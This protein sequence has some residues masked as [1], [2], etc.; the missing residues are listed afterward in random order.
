MKNALKDPNAV[1]DVQ[2]LM[3][4]GLGKL[5]VYGVPVEDLYRDCLRMA[6]ARLVS[7]GPGVGQKNARRYR[8]ET[9]CPHIPKDMG[10]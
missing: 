10:K 4:A 1:F 8:V 2:E 3:D 5:E 6:N 9:K 7:V